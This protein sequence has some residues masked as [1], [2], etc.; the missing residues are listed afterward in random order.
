MEASESF[1][2]LDTRHAFFFIPKLPSLQRN[3]L[4]WL[5]GTPI[6]NFER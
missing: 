6:A 5:A 3:T 4:G 1:L 2:S